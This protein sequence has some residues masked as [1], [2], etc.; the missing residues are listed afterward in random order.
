MGKPSPHSGGARGHGEAQPAQRRRPGPRGSQTWTAEVPGATG[1]QTWTAEVPG[2]MGKPSP[3][4]G[5]A[6]GHG[7]VRPR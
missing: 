7:E 2:A 4:S 5:G 6:Q 3:H 1:S